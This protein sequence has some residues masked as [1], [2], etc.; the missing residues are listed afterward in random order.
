MIPCVY[1]KITGTECIGCGMNRA[2]VEVCQ[3]NIK[4]AWE[5]NPLF[6][7][8]VPLMLSF[9][10]IDYLRFKKKKINE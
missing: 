6:F 4:K 8:F 1:S 9:L 7:I 3:L 10:T 2:A 5:Y